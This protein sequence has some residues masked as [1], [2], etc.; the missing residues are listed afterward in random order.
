MIVIVCTE[1]RGGMLFNNRRVS[2]DRMVIQKILELSEGKKLWIHPFS[3]KLFEQEHPENCCV[4]ENFLEKAGEGDICFVENQSLKGMEG[5]IEKLIVFGWNRAYPFDFKLD[6]DL[7]QMEKMAE[8][9]FAGYSH[10][11]ITLSQYEKRSNV[12]DTIKKTKET[13]KDRKRR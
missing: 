3:E 1:D 7:E 8:E 2:K 10:E 12:T 13:G 11:K 6:L 5:Q 9:E 4:D